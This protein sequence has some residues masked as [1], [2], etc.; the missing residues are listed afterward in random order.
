MVK[1]LW[2]MSMAVILVVV[3][4]CVEVLFGGMYRYN[5]EQ[6]MGEYR[7]QSEHLAKLIEGGGNE[8]L[9]V[10]AGTSDLRI[11]WISPDGILLFDSKK[12]EPLPNDSFQRK[13]VSQAKQEGW[14]VDKNAAATL[15][16]VTGSVTQ[17]LTDGTYLRVSGVRDSFLALVMD[18][19][20]QILLILLGAA[21]ATLWLSQRIAKGVAA[22][23]DAIDLE[24]LD[25]RTVCPE[26]Q[27]A[28]ARIASLNRQ[29]QKQLQ[30]QMNEL[31]REYEKQDRMRRDFT[32]NVSHELKTPLTSISGYA[33]LLRAGIVREE[34]RD[35]FAGKI[36][37][38]TQRLITLV[39]DILKLSQLDDGYQV[40]IERVAIDLYAACQ[41]VVARL[42]SAADQRQVT[43]QLEGG[44]LLIQ[45]AEQ[46]VDEIIYN[47]CDNAIKYN[48]VGGT[49]TVAVYP[50]EDRAVLLVK[51]TGIGIPQGEDDRV[52]ERFYR[53]DKSHSK[54]IGGTGLGL[55]IVKHGAAFH[56]AKVS[57]ES[58]EGQGTVIRLVFPN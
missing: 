28:L 7:R 16:T 36:Y 48:K 58:T 20:W 19:L 10:L 9:P 30:V 37:E 56:N 53:V 12:G 23:L 31:K 13:D 42:Q 15:T 24:H 38:E 35:R 51:D 14:G 32:A 2:A 1:K 22:P 54:E 43:F 11:T 18:R 34:D 26:L 17:R 44:P 46:V 21:I 29:R 6:S 3:A 47:L 52:F 41:R 55:S 8:L 49:V 33:E 5:T 25:N 39:G 45:G 40:R 50:Q 4:L 57:L 27:P